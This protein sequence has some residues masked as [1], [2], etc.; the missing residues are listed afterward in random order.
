MCVVP[1]SLHKVVGKCTLVC[2]A[3]RPKIFVAHK[4]CFV[5]GRLSDIGVSRPLKT[6]PKSE[7]LDVPGNESVVLGHNQRS[8]TNAERSWK[9]ELR[10]VH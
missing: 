4:G 6:S 2:F 9:L 8:S 3:N 10:S 5:D 1:S 7:N